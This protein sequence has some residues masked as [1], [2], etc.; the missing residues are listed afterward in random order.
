MNCPNCNQENDNDN[1]F[2]V[3]CGGH[4]APPINSG[5]T[6]QPSPT[7]YYN[8]G[9]INKPDD[10][11]ESVQTAFAPAPN[12][13][14]SPAPQF[15]A[16][17]PYIAA[18]PKRKSNGKFV[19]FGALALLLLIGAVVGAVFIFNSQTK[20]TSAERLPDHLGLFLLNKEADNFSELSKQD[21]TNAVL[22]KDDLLKNDALPAT[23]EKPTLILYSDGKDIPF[24]DLKLVQLDTIKDDG[25]LKQINFQASP[26]EGKPEMKR[27]RI[28]D[29]LANGK[30]AFALFDGF[31]DEGKHKF[32]AF[33][34]KNAA[35]TDNGDLAK[36]LS[37]SV[38]PKTAAPS[39]NSINSA[40]SAT[41]P[42]VKV[43]PTPK[44]ETA[45][46][47]GARVAYSASSNVIMRN[48]PSLTARKVNGLQ[49]GQKVYVIN[50]SSNYDSWNG[51]EGN[52]A[53]VQTE[54][55]GRGWVFTPL[56]NY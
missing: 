40:N 38:K 15:D 5:A 53:Y 29:G 21:S 50:Y 16:S 6:T 44:P 3:S 27:L 13:N 1:I 52:W 45:A 48:A 24:G 37:F 36:A 39:N 19:L 2:C 32:W 41:T 18:A 46:P 26:V 11:P 51:M 4:L 55:G 20:T 17:I 43:A 12:I 23:D 14:A 47:A 8:P 33:Q 56:I 34:V 42:I 28:A 10:A 9:Q 49:R 7:Q 31:L 22:T 35:K 25:S 30:Y 54:S